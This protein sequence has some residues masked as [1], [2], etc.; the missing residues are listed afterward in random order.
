MASPAFERLRELRGRP[1]NFL[2][3]SQSVEGEMLAALALDE[4]YADRRLPTFAQLEEI[5][6]N[7]HA[8]TGFHAWCQR[9]RRFALWTREAIDELAT[10]LR[11]RAFSRIVELGAGRGDLAWHLAQA[12]VDVIATDAGP[13]MLAG[14]TLEQYRE[15][16]VDMWENV[17][18]IDW[19]AALATLTPDCVLCSWMPPDEDWTPRIRATPS[20]QEFILFWELRG[21]TGGASAFQPNPGWTPRDL[22]DVE[23]YLVGR[24]DEGM[25]GWG[26]TQYTRATA[27]RRIES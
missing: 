12:G 14:Y 4:L 1:Y 6:T 16:P 26:V 17:R 10:Y 25:P 2:S 24:T 27:F 22:L 5:I 21:T 9:G 11:Q 8:L 13:S 18:L 7:P 19:R 15:I 23:Q 3:R 20:V